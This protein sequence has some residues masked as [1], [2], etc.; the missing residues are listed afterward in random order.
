MLTTFLNLPN[1][2]RY[3]YNDREIVSFLQSGEALTNLYREMMNNKLAIVVS[4]VIPSE[5]HKILDLH[6]VVKH[7]K[8]QAGVGQWEYYLLPD[9]AG[10]TNLRPILQPLQTGTGIASNQ[11]FERILDQVKEHR[12]TNPDFESTTF[13]SNKEM[14]MIF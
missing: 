3:Y 1:N 7:E 5:D 11:I 6:I 14:L 9:F 8:R 12:N 13:L 10:K 2:G 4:L